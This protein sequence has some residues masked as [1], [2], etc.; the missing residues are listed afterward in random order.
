[1]KK[2]EILLDWILIAKFLCWKKGLNINYLRLICLIMASV[3]RSNQGWEFKD[4]IFR[5]KIFVWVGF[6]LPV[7]D[8]F[9]ISFELLMTIISDCFESPEQFVKIKFIKNFLNNFVTTAEVKA[10]IFLHNLEI[11]WEVPSA[12]SA[13]IQITISCSLLFWKQNIAEMLCGFLLLKF[14][15]RD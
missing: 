10:K 7:D 14:K 15:Y 1:M 2:P 12:S 3:D 4:C 6:K 13:K 5:F 9:E 11:T 8:Q